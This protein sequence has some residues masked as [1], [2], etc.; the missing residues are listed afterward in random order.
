[1][2]RFQ[3]PAPGPGVPAPGPEPEPGRQRRGRGGSKLPLLA[4]VGVGI[5]V[6]G[7]GAGAM[8]SGGGG[9][10]DDDKK[11]DNKSLAATEPA[12]SDKPSPSADPSKK[13]AVAL[14][15]LLADS[16]N[17]RETVIGAVR[18]V[19]KCSNLKQAATDLRAAAKQRDGLVGRLSGLT[20][21]KLPKNAQL[22]AALNK[23]WKA[24]A[25]ADN[26]Y[27]AWADQVARKKGCRKGHARQTNHS[28]AGNRAS[29]EATQ[30][31]QQA[32]TLWNAIAQQHGL[33][34]RDR[35]QL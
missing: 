29:G 12:E 5:A 34:K 13:Q 19:G 35:T 26:H 24:S 21:D 20:V 33:T 2:P 7:V 30:A 15:K 3:V 18:D 17:S 4:A 9:G 32:A 16:N 31:K 6:L 14:D 23:A 10:G 1:M 8:L 25:S 22:T 28:A 11:D 27:A